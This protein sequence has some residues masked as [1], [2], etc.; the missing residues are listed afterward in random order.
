MAEL[1]VPENIGVGIIRWTLEGD[2][3]E[4][5]VTLG[6]QSTRVTFDAEIMAEDLRA[7]VEAAGSLVGAAS[8]MYSQW[9]FVG[10]TVRL[11]T[12][13]GFLS[14]EAIANTVGTATGETLP[15][16]S[17][18]L[19]KKNT[20]SGGRRFRGRMYLPMYGL[21]ESD[22]SSSGVIAGAEVTSLQNR[23]DAFLAALD[24]NELIPLLLHYPFGH[25]DESDPPEFIIDDPEPDP[26]IIT[27]FAVQNRIATQRR[28]LR[29]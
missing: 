16:N 19:I 12:S 25:W 6:L 26:T 9:T 27:S 4:M 8:G 1:Y 3:E 11:Q 13:T 5:V 22:V 2:S 7:A 18:I 14:G 17:A 24:T 29:R 21:E 15:N 20:G 10:T 28:R 23:L